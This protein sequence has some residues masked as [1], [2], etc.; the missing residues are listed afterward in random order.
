VPALTFVFVEDNQ[1]QRQVAERAI[2]EAGHQTLLVTAADE[3]EALLA[4]VTPA[5]VVVSSQLPAELARAAIAVARTQRRDAASGA[6]LPGPVI[7]LAA[8]AADAARTSDEDG[9]QVDALL[10]R[11]AVGCV[12]RPYD[13]RRLARQLEL[14]SVGAAPARILVIDD[15]PT[16]LQTTTVILEQAGHE[17][18][19]ASDGQEGMA[20]LAAAPG[21]DLVLSDVMMP[22]LD[23]YGVCE[24]IR[25]H[26]A[27]RGLPVLLLTSLRD[28]GSQSR[29]L[30][31]GA[32][33]VL[34]KPIA[35]AELSLRV[36]SMLRLKSLQRR[37]A[38]RNQELEE[39]LALREQLTHM[40]V[41]DF[42]NPLTRVL[43]SAEMI[44]ES[45][46]VAKVDEAVE[47]AGDILS[48]A[49]RLRGLADDLLQVARIE[50][51]VAA[52][53]RQ[54]LVLGEI[55]DRIVAD[56]RTMA[57]ARKVTLGVEIE[58]DL[59]VTVDREWIYRVLQNL[60]DNALKYSPTGGHIG[61]IARFTYTALG[62]RVHVQVMDDGPGIPADYRERVFDKFSQVPK[63]SRRGTGLGLTFCRLA[64]E[65]H[66]GRIGVGDRP[67]GKPGSVFELTLPVA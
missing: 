40:L 11:G 28:I 35:P 47:L 34:T 2:E 4:H 17:T 61:V 65:A 9:R 6:T 57:R 29:A 50:E 33:D 19:R 37:L 27:W 13:K 56:M 42:R 39:A 46:A 23:G 30:E 36:R 43:I 67:D 54:D 12:A 20:K 60:L 22:R 24:A 5:V 8:A 44:A 25:A 3:L 62:P 49:Q 45:C 15:S 1:L 7:V 48:G 31:A 32:D 63:T 52:P 64:V 55:I 14:Y 59:R 38:R 51:G 10:A 26:P 18:L 66:G 16:T 58:R 53:N 41:H 21:V